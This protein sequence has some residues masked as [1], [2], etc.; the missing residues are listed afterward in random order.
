[1]S[2]YTLLLKKQVFDAFPLSSKTAKNKNLISYLL[3]A[4]LIA[5]IIAAFALIFSQ[6]TK[7]Y[8]QI[9]IN[10]VP[11]VSARQFE[12]MSVVYFAMIVAFIVTGTSRL[13]YTL[14]ENSDIA[15]LISMPFSAFEIFA[16]KL[17]WLYVRQT[18]VSLFAV[19]T[20]NLTFFISTNLISAYNV[21]M[22]FFVALILPI[23]PLSIAAVLA[24]PYY[25]L[26]RIITS[27]YLLNFAA[28]TALLVV[29]CILYAKL[30]G[31]AENLL[32]TG[33]LSSLFNERTM[34]QIANFAKN[35]YP[36]NL[37]AGIMLGRDIGKNIGILLGILLGALA[38]GLPVI[39]AIFIKVTQTGFGAHVPHVSHK[40]LR[41]IRRNRILSLIN[42][43]FIT[44]LRTP[45]YAYMYFAT[46]IIMPVMS[47]YSAKL[48]TSLLGGMLGN[49]RFD[50]ELCTFI[51]ILYATLTNTFC[52]TNIS[53]DG[54]MSM[55]Q[56][57]LPYSPQQI[58]SAKMIFSGIVSEASI[59]ITCITLCA[60]GL[61]GAGDGI[62]TFISASMLAAAQ[63]MFATRL[64][65]NHPHFSRSDDGEIK[66]A[67]T[68][69][70]VIILVGLA[71]CLAI[72]VLLLY[73]TVSGLITG[74]PSATDK[75]I[76][77]AY[78]LAIPFALLAAAAAFFFVNLKQVYQN[79]DAER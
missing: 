38:I 69:V 10:R 31:I 13:C 55:M 76:S 60:S 70:S 49:V 64:D 71:V 19:L 7:T 66:E 67:N 72:G 24:L 79:L 2:R 61:E 36:A 46:A 5:C 40:E 42:K 28:M 29:F 53:R 18:L 14:F 33:R 4:V 41:F 39:H 78:S 74:T 63:I 62:I 37:I 44:V 52:S 43:E 50:F 30:F 48:G 3:M 23:L 16:S 9:K 45:G 58:L 59:L 34:L 25:Y 73:N 47:Y 22:S 77:Y 17:T 32:G 57:T 20:V 65:L 21:L 15:I 27:H 6:F 26:K 1:M 51:V 35:A 75:G 11:D 54:Y 68:T 56:K 12:I 8:S